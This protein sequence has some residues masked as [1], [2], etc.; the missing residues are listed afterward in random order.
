[1]TDDPSRNTTRS[2]QLSAAWPVS[3]RTIGKPANRP[4]DAAF[5]GLLVGVA[6]VGVVALIV[7]L[8]TASRPTKRRR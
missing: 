5:V 4:S 3:A 1:M 7:G 6:L 2:G 8:L